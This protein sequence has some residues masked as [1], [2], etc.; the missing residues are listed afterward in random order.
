MKTIGTSLLLILSASAM[1]GQTADVKPTDTIAATVGRN[2]SIQ[3]VTAGKH[4]LVNVVARHPKIGCAD[5]AQCGDIFYSEESHNLVINAGLNWLADIM[6][7][8]TTPGVNL[9]CNYFAVTPTAIT[10]GATDTALSGEIVTNGFN[11]TGVIG[12][13][14]RAQAVYAHTAN[15]TTYTLSYT[16]TAAAT[17]TIAGAAV[18]TA[19]S[20]TTMC[21]E[22]AI[23]SASLLSGDTLQIVWTVTI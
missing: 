9:Q 2:R 21:F 20:S 16:Y 15:A 4:N 7:K 19:S 5:T 17:Q 18:F 8:N 6:S 11:S 10:P 1:F 3:E 23:T 14:V 12:S 22:D 13:G